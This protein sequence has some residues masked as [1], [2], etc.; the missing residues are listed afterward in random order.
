LNL[1]TGQWQQEDPLGFAAGDPNLRRYVRNGPTNATDPSGLERKPLISFTFPTPASIF[2]D[3]VFGQVGKLT[4]H[5]FGITPNPAFKPMFTNFSRPLAYFNPL[6]VGTIPLQVLGDVGNL[7]IGAVNAVYAYGNEVYDALNLLGRGNITGFGA[8]ITAFS[9]NEFG[10]VGMDLPLGGFPL[11]ELT[12]QPWAKSFDP[13]AA[14]LGT[15]ASPLATLGILAGIS[16]FRPEPNPGAL[17]LYSDLD[18]IDTVNQMGTECT[19][20]TLELSEASGGAGHEITINPPPNCDSVAW[21]TMDGPETGGYH[22]VF[23]DGHFVFDPR[24]DPVNPIPVEDWLAQVDELNGGQV[25]PEWKPPR[26]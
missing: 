18:F 5:F 3:F 20:I 17:A 16:G 10:P 21:P 1:K 4:D 15:T 24:L 23:T 9:L 8:S 14:E 11:Y 26:K 22:S 7:G 12:I 19:Q 2:G 13:D 25:T 6:A